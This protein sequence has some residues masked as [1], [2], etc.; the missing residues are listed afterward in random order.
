[1]KQEILKILKNSDSY[2]SGEVISNQLNVTRAAVWKAINSL[3]TQGYDIVS[4]KHHG[5]KLEDTATVYNERELRELM[6]R[7]ELLRNVR[8]KFFGEIDSTNLAA[9]RDVDKL[10]GTSLY[11]ADRQ[12]A[13]RGRL[14][15]TWQSEPDNGIWLSVMLRPQSNPDR[16]ANLTLFAGLCVQRALVKHTGI[17]I[18]IKWPNDLVAMPSGRKICGILTETVLEDMQVRAV[19]IGIGINVNNSSFADDI[20]HIAGSL[21]LES[22]QIYDRGRLLIDILHELIG[23]FHEFESGLEAK[24]I[25]PSWMEGYRQA[26]V[27]LGRRVSVSGGGEAAEGLASGLTAG[28]DLTVTMDDGSIK[29]CHSGEVS[30]RGLAGYI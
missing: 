29:T 4:M 5:Y 7:S 6:D 14:G 10:S 18:G 12:L 2:V 20:K 13:G 15:R 11:V 22:G 23:N 26:C 3:R 19:I 17:E 16:L 28:G 9:R 8:L 24:H 1:M 30:V 25:E 21:R 27:T